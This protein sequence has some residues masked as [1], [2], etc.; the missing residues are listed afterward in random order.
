LAIKL[1]EFA[2]KCIINTYIYV[3]Q[4][5][6]GTPARR[7]SGVLPLSEQRLPDRMNIVK[8]TSNLLSLII[9]FTHLDYLCTLHIFVLNNYKTEDKFKEKGK[10]YGNVALKIFIKLTSI[11]Y[12]FYLVGKQYI[13][14]K[15]KIFNFATDLGVIYLAIIVWHVTPLFFLKIIMAMTQ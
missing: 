11:Y 12:C 14:K 13:F 1:W 6:Y 8:P 2:F 15:S 7:H 9:F 10:L 3:Q 5:H 4:T